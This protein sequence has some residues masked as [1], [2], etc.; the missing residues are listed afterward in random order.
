MQILLRPNRMD[1]RL[2]SK[3]LR[4]V[5]PGS[6]SKHRF[7]DGLSP[8]NAAVLKQTV[9]RNKPPAGIPPYAIGPERST[10]RFEEAQDPSCS[11]IRDNG[12]IAVPQVTG[13]EVMAQLGWTKVDL[14]KVDIEGWER[15]LFG[16]NAGWLERVSCIVGEIHEGHDDAALR[17]DLQPHGFSVKLPQANP[18]SDNRSFWRREINF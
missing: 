9:A 15:V 12:T 6:G 18:I 16:E 4:A 8:Q 10:V 2:M 7:S 1:S 3:C 17:A 5:D 14:L 13:P 11:V